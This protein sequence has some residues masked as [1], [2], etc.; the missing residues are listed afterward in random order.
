MRI[1]IYVRVSTLRQAQA[2]SIEQQLSRLHEYV[3]R[4]GWALPAENIFRDD[5]HS[6]ATLNR[7]GLDRYATRCACRSWTVSW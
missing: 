2:Q 3:E 4:R 6:G 5:G 7:S 1:G